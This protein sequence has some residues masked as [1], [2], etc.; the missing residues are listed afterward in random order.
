VVTLVNNS[1]AVMVQDTNSRHR[2]RLTASDIQGVSLRIAHDINTRNSER[3]QLFLSK[4]KSRF[5]HAATITIFGNIVKWMTYLD[6]PPH[7]VASLPENPNGLGVLTSPSKGSSFASIFL[8]GDFMSI[9]IMNLVWSAA[10]YTD[11]RTL[12]VLLA[13]ADWSNDEGM[14]WPSLPKLAI[15][16]RQSSRNVQRIL[17]SLRDEGV[18]RIEVHDGRNHCNRYFLNLA[19]LETTTPCRGLPLD[20]PELPVE[21][22]VEKANPA[23]D[24]TRQV[25]PETTTNDPTTHDTA[26]SHNPSSTDPSRTESSKTEICTSIEGAVGNSKAEVQTPSSQKAKT[27]EAELAKRLA[28]WKVPFPKYAAEMFWHICEK[29]FPALTVPLLMLQLELEWE[30][31]NQRAVSRPTAYL[32]DAC[33]TAFRRKTLWPEHP[34]PKPPGWTSIG[35]LTESFRR[36]VDHDPMQ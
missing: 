14:S 20:T 9:K 28:T 2:T 32:I 16:S 18:L 19:V 15:K 7:I 22:P 21:K 31:A 13:L 33:R 11:P 4:Y 30:H 5:V 23:N 1:T 24:K 34:P 8:R 25:E 3:P 17:K 26:L 35:R 12:L 36:G 27:A 6:R 29:E 10:Q